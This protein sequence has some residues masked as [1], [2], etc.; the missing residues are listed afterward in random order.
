MASMEYLKIETKI[1]VNDNE[2]ISFVSSKGA[3]RSKFSC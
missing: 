1:N 2:W 3:V